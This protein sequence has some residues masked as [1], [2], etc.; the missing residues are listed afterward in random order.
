MPTITVSAGSSIQTAINAAAAGDTINVAAGTFSGDITVSKRLTLNGA[1]KTSTIISGKISITGAGASAS[2]RLVISNL[3]V[4]GGTEGIAISPAATGSYYTIENVNASSSTGSG[5]HI[6]STGT[7][8]DVRI[9]SCTLSSNG[10]SGLRIASAITSMTGL[11]MS[12]CTVANNNSSGLSVNASGYNKT[13]NNYTF[14]NCTFTNNNAAN[15]SNQHQLSFFGFKGNATLTNVSVTANDTNKAYGIS[16]MGNAGTSTGAQY[17]VAG[18]SGTV[19]LTDVTVSGTVGKAALSFQGYTNVSAISLSG[20]SVK[21]CV[22]GWQD[23][24]IDHTSGSSLN[25]GDTKLKNIS[26][27]KSGG[28][29]ATNAAFYNLSGGALLNKS[30]SADCDVILSQI[31]A[32]KMSGTNEGFAALGLVLF[33]ANTIFVRAPLPSVPSPYTLLTDAVNKAI[34]LASAG[35]TVSVAAGTYSGDVT[36]NKGVALNGAGKASTIISGKVD[37]TGSG[38]DESNR[39]VVSNVKVSGGISIKPSSAGSY[40]TI[41][42]V[43]VSGAA[44]GVDINATAAVSDVNVLSS[45]LSYSSV[46]GVRVASAVTNL[47]VSDCMIQNNVDGFAIVAGLDISGKNIKVNNNELLDNSAKAINHAGTGA[48]DATHNWYGSANAAVV[49]SKISGNVTY[50]PFNGGADTS[51]VSVDE[52]NNI[53]VDNN[54]ITTVSS[55][56]DAVKA[57]IDAAAANDAEALAPLFASILDFKSEGGKD[58]IVESM[59]TTLQDETDGASYVLTEEEKVEI[60]AGIEDVPES[61]TLVVADKDNVLH[62]PTDASG[63]YMLMVPGTPYIIWNSFNNASVTAVF[64]GGDTLLVTPLTPTPGLQRTY[65][66]GDSL[67]IGNE[68]I[69]IWKIG[70]FGGGAGGAPCFP[71]GTRILTPTG[72]RTVETLKQGDLVLTAAGLSVPV[73]LYRSTIDVATRETAPFVIP[74]HS[75]GRNA[76]AAELRLSPLHAFQIK[77]GVWQSARHA[78]NDKLYQYGIGEAVTYYHIECPNFFRDNLVVDGCVVESFAANQTKGMKTIYT[79]SA[80]LGGFTRVSGPGS[81]SVSGSVSRA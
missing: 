13:F 41:D 78:N 63:I 27:W 48:L 14:T 66:V 76:P 29:D 49:A 28:V 67:R 33:K 23:V 80:R 59:I 70:S 44:A 81:S 20:V 45:T 42:T 79:P 18:A 38:S 50:R 69:P 71:V 21:D 22:S 37:I 51:A 61:V 53:V 57:A 5:I 72:Y 55:A 19:S 4:T 25:L 77:K 6:N 60:F 15:T 32:D 1:G 9:Y 31:S 30:V 65:R 47:E 52:S 36:V 43:D 35:Y 56:E 34:G 74:A 39:L 16:F 3:K 24:V 73:T 12:G 75:F 46:A 8:A 64:N 58:A 62:P 10:N 7:V 68:S 54:E 17:A 26:I 40:Y 11:D 2:D